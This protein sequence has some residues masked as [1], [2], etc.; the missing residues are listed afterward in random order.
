[1]KIEVFILPKNG[2]V[3]L[4]PSDPCPPARRAPTTSAESAKPQ[5]TLTLGAPWK[6]AVLSVLLVGIFTMCGMAIHFAHKEI[7]GME[8]F[9]PKNISQSAPPATAT[10]RPSDTIAVADD[11]SRVQHFDNS[12]SLRRGDVVVVRQK[13]GANVERVAV[14][15]NSTGVFKRGNTVEALYVLGENRYLVASERGTRIVKGHDILA[16]VNSAKQQR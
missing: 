8:N 14:A 15:A 11:Q 5:H 3:R 4:A 6:L 7:S 1:M 9:S 16:T 10:A 13:D 12:H 2:E